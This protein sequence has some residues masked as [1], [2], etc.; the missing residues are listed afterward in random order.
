[1]ELIMLADD[2]R[3]EGG[4][5]ID[6]HNMRDQ[7]ELTWNG[8]ADDPSGFARHL[9]NALLENDSRADVLQ[10]HPKW[11]AQGAIKGW[12]PW[13]EIPEG[14]LFRSH[15]GFLNGAEGTDGVQF[16][17]WV[18]YH[19]GGQTIWSR[20]ANL[21]KTYDGRMIQLDADLSF[22]AGRRAGIELR[23]DAGNS[24]GKDWA[25]WQAP[26]VEEGTGSASLWRL[27]AESLTVNDRNETRRVEGR[28][29]EP[30][31][32]AVYF[33][34]IFGI[35]G[36][37]KV[38]V[39]DALTTLGDNVGAGESVPV[40]DLSVIDVGSASGFGLMGLQIVAMERDKR[41]KDIVRDKLNETAR[42]LRA[43]LIDHVENDPVG[44]AD[45]DTTRAELEASVSDESGDRLRHKIKKAFTDAA[46]WLL[47]FDDLIDQNGLFLVSGIDDA[48][49]E[50][51]LGDEFTP[52]SDRDPVSGLAERNFNLTFAGADAEYS[53]MVSLRRSNITRIVSG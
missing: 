41:G 9:N 50:R 14:G 12:F 46:S 53:V 28:G 2:A 37:T 32:G 23:V 18:H 49:L 5:L 40:T 45:I 48:T 6:D 47:R 26:R 36:S 30:Y 17:V 35:P 21:H 16:Q 20:A 42:K 4:R 34:S 44:W 13:F 39:L 24:S 8:S 38:E 11:N 10:M 52:G 3:W 15:V 1:M 29:D 7:I 25:V 31:L 19:V 22:L 33:R 27:S 51:F 43:G